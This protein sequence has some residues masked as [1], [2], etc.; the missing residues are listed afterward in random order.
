MAWVKAP[1]NIKVGTRRVGSGLGKRSEVL[2]VFIASPA[3]PQITPEVYHLIGLAAS[4]SGVY[5]TALPWL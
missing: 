1:Q 4:I 2:A 3:R 5:I